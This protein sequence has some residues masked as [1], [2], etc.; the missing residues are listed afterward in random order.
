MGLDPSQL[1]AGFQDSVKK[2]KHNQKALTERK[3]LD[4][5][6]KKVAPVYGI[7]TQDVR[8][9]L[10]HPEPLMWLEMEYPEMPARCMA[11]TTHKLKV[12]SLFNGKFFKSRVW[13]AFLSVVDK[14]GGCALLVCRAGRTPWVVGNV[15]TA[16]PRK[17]KLARVV[18]PAAAP[19]P[20]AYVMP[21]KS[22]VKENMEETDV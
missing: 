22:F 7:H 19:A 17:L 2:V 3:L 4:T 6:I 10:H 5:L 13:R 18:I 20:D 1:A 8:E 14:Q 12:G 9:A 11:V 16:A 15:Y 21:L